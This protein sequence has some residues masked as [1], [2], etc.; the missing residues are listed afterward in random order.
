MENIRFLPSPFGGYPFTSTFPNHTNVIK[1]VSLR[2]KTS[3]LLQ[4]PSSI[5]CLY[6]RPFF[7]NARPL[8]EKRIGSVG[9][10]LGSYPEWRMFDPDRFLINPTGI[11]MQSV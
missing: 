7:N 8:S 10:A 6:Q 2:L 3:I 5:F 11:I 1:D 9:G 4:T